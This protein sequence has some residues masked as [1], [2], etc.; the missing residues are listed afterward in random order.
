MDIFKH[1][2]SSITKTLVDLKGSKILSGDHRLEIADSSDSDFSITVQGNHLNNI[3]WF[4]SS[5]LQRTGKVILQSLHSICKGSRN[6]SHLA[7]L[8]EITAL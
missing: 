3:A 2:L 1:E 6:H 5:V 4:L 7:L 8:F